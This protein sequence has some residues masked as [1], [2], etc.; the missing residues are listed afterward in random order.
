MEITYVGEQKPL[1][2]LERFQNHE[3]SAAQ[4]CMKTDS[5]L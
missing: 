2:Q 5:V 3:I 1:N 4:L